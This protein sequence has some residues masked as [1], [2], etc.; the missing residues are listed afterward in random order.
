MREWSISTIVFFSQHFKSVRSL[1]AFQDI[2][3]VQNISAFYKLAWFIIFALGSRETRGYILARIFGVCVKIIIIELLQPSCT[4]SRNLRTWTINYEQKDCTNIIIN[5][6]VENV[7]D[8][9]N[10]WSTVWRQQRKTKKC[11]KLR[12]ATIWEVSTLTIK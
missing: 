7:T 10:S 5:S 6:L 1:F 3:V 8:L 12:L 2:K 4:I 9:S 11:N